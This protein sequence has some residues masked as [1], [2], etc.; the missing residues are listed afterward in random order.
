ME[1][2]KRPQAR[3]LPIYPPPP[4]QIRRHRAA[5]YYLL[6]EKA[7]KMLQIYARGAVRRGGGFV[8]HLY[9]IIGILRMLSY[10][11]ARNYVHTKLLLRTARCVTSYR[12][13]YVIFWSRHL[14]VE[15]QPGGL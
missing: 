9:I 12:L 1:A 10:K 3:F 7:R 14:L 8:L 4:Q 6:Y 5:C 2:H 11:L 13:D 15:Y